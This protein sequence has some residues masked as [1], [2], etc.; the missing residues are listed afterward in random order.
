MAYTVV[1]RD[2]LVDV[3]LPNGNRY[4]GG[5]T[6]LLDDEEYGVIPSATGIVVFSATTYTGGGG[7]ATDLSAFSAVKHGAVGDGQMAINGSITTGTKDLVCPSGPF[8]LLDVT[9]HIMIKGSGALGVTTQLATIDQFI[10][11]TH[12]KISVNATT[13]VTG[14]LVM[15]GSDDTAAFQEAINNAVTYAQTHGGAATLSI[16]APA[17][18]FYVIA[19]A[20]VTGGATL[21]NS[22][23]T[24]PVV[25][26]AGAKI[27]LTIKGVSIGS[28]VQHWL[29]QVPTLSGSTL[30]SFGVCSS[31]SAQ[32]TMIDAHGNPAVIGGPAQ[33]GGYGVAPGIYSNM[34]VVLQDL[35]ILTSHSLNGLTYSAFDFSGLACAGL[36]DIAFGTTGNVPAGDFAAPNSFANGLSIGGLMPANGNNDHCVVSN[37]TVFGGYTYGIWATEHT[38]VPDAI[39]LLYCWS[40]LCVV[41]Q[42][43]NSVGATHGINVEQ[44]SIEA[45]VNEVHFIGTGSN[46]VGPDLR[47]GQLDTETSA[48]TINGTQAGLAAATGSIR[49]SGLYN[50]DNFT[51]AFPCGVLNSDSQNPFPE[52]TVTANYQVLAIDDTIYI[53]ATAGNVTVTL[54][55]AVSSPRAYTF[56]RVDA[57]GHTASV[58]PFGAE[59]I[60]GS[61]SALTLTG[62]WATTIVRPKSNAWTAH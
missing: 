54:P 43:F 62:Q 25:P 55:S 5:E 52:K 60:N 58:A 7:G 37:I 46:G 29:Q 24:L 19:G 61:A 15:W 50:R 27:T 3:V 47:I 16:P 26:T 4:Q 57:S 53:D 9:K 28:A 59:T 36:R 12:V 14:A 23:L 8:Q 44:A 49:W 45:C 1:L 32:S 6:A 38:V 51:T 35:V 48:P 42:Y 2:G 11:D 17:K 34:L 31:S 20:L 33:P 41:G 39:R 13:T 10:D 18:M 21:G 40:G 56:Q 30:V 22:Q